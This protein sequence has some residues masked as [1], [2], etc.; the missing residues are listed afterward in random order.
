[1]LGIASLMIPCGKMAKNGRVKRFFT[2]GLMLMAVG[3]IASAMCVIFGNFWI[4]IIFRIIQGV[5]AAMFFAALP[6]II[7]RYLP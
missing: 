1:M 5:G 6:C 4:M 7:V 2:I 3:S